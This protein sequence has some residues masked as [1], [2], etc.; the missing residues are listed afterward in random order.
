MLDQLAVMPR[1]EAYKD[2][3]VE[4]L[5]EIPEH[6]QVTRLKFV[7]LEHG[8]N[9]FPVEF[10]GSENGTI[11]FFK[12]SDISGGEVFTSAAANYVDEATIKKKKMEYYSPRLF[13]DSKNRGSSS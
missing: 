12:V 2:S 11:P 7:V 6:W 4:W 10:Q 5:G 9:G 3:G 8:G 13:V 1:Y